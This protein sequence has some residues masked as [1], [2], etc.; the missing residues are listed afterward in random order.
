MSARGI[1]PRGKEQRTTYDDCWAALRWASAAQDSWLAEHGDVSRLFVAGDSAGGN[2]VHNLLVRA[3][4]LMFGTGIEGAILLHP[5][6]VGSTAVEGESERAVAITAKLWAFACPDAAGGA[7][8]AW[9]NPIAPGAAAAGLERLGCK[10]VL[11]CAAE[12][13]WLAA[14]DRAYYEAVVASG[15]PGSAAWL[16]SEGVGHVFF[17]LKPDFEKNKQLM[18]RVVAFIAGS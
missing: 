9:I 18:D 10:R 6:F 1:S 3:S 14:R 2:I 8:D 15:W 7:D 13:D 17:L 11:V 12:M 5:F 16:E 4:S